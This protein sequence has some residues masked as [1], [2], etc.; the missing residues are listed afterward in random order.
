MPL[1]AKECAS[2]IC[3]IKGGKGEGSG[4]GMRLSALPVEDVHASH[5]KHKTTRR[6]RTRMLVPAEENQ[7]VVLFVGR[8]H[9]PWHLEGSLTDP[10]IVLHSPR[11][12]FP[13]M[14]GEDDS[15]NLQISHWTEHVVGFKD[16]M[17]L[18]Q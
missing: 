10:S 12:G 7:W 15:S 3:E 6:C 14:L 11:V 8:D 13:L 2:L 1:G 4:A 17:F 5:R 18:G 9:V 16:N